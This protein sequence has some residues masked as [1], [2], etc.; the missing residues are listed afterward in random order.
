MRARPIAKSGPDT[1]LVEVKKSDLARLGITLTALPFADEDAAVGQYAAVVSGVHKTIRSPM[2][3]IDTE[4]I[5]VRRAGSLSDEIRGD[6]GGPAVG[7]QNGQTVVYGITHHLSQ[8]WINLTYP[9][10]WRMLLAQ[11]SEAGAVTQKIAK[12]TFVSVDLD[13]LKH[14]LA[15]LEGAA[16]ESSNS[17][18]ITNNFY[19]ILLLAQMNYLKI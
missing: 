6:S 1:A 2:I 11:M 19:L 16:E 8:P 15:F 7:I 18:F 13:L 12:K 17:Y 5:L 14:A 4:G 9:N 10:G 3:I